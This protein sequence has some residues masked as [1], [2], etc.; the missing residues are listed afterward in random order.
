MSAKPI[1]QWSAVATVRAIKT[2]QVS[3]LDVVRA[4]IERMR[5]VNPLVNAVFA[6]LGGDAQVRELLGND[7]RFTSAV[8]VL[9]LP[10]AVVPVGLHQGHPVGAQ[11]I[12]SRYREDLCLD[13]AQAIERRAGVLARELWA[14][15]SQTV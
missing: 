9:G 4:H 8:N 5:S 2:K 13:A 6:D 10:A 7:L 15:S 11:L 12:A 14:R 1:W 3:S